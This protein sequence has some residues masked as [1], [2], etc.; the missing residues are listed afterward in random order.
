MKY[1][2]AVAIIAAIVLAPSCGLD[3][4]GLVTEPV[5]SGSLWTR[6]APGLHV[7]IQ[8][9]VFWVGEGASDDN[10]HIS[11]VPNCWQDDWVKHHGCADTETG[12]CQSTENPYYFALPYSDMKDGERKGNIG[13]IPWVSERVW[14]DSESI[15]KN[16][17]IQVS[18]QGVDCY[19]QWEDCGPYLEDDV[20]YVFGSSPPKN[21]KDLKSGLDLSPALAK[22]LGATKNQRVDWK[23][24]DVSAV[25]EG[26]WRERITE[27]QIDWD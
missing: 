12:P 23:F 20:S 2:L 16:R 7:G 26:P 27:S 24:V 8:S 17:W 25:P 15:V 5:P 3:E 14:E 18:Y 21:K 11:N 9:T 4:T 10:G 19:A 6:G 13:L 22:C 1:L